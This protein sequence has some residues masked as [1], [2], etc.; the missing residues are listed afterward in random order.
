MTLLNHETFVCFDCET[1]GLDT[2]QDRIIE[3]A[4]V[5]FTF[6]EVI[7]SFE[8]L[9]DPQKEISADSMAIHH[10]SQE[11]VE[12]KP[13]IEN[14]LDNFFQFVGKNIIVGH[15]IPFDI[16]MVSKSAERHQMRSPLSLCPF[17]DTLRLAR[18]YGQASINS[19]ESLRKHFNIP[20]EGAHRAMSDVVVNI[21]VFK[22]LS[23]AF[24]TSD[25]IFQ[26]LSKPV[27]LKA[28]P[29]GKHK[30]RAFKEIPLEYLQWAV[31]KDF[32]QDLIHS[33]RSEIKRRKKGKLFSQAYNP[34]SDL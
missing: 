17:I 24:K 3:I 10:I 26:V 21:E 23:K 27:E 19:L 18:H 12:G 34:F 30:G 8:T 32:D 13:L 25:Q 20:Y 29:L 5:K 22:N 11:M 2:D 4:A 6:N 15:G 33:L 28:M 7:D 9:I 1:T 14:I 16:E 31:H